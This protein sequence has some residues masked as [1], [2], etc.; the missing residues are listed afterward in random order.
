VFAA[1]YL[2]GVL[3]KFLF[4]S[5]TLILI[6]G[7][8]STPS[9]NYDGFNSAHD[10]CYSFIYGKNDV[11]KSYDKAFKWC[12]IGS[13]KEKNNS[14]T[15]LLAELYL[16]G[17]G[18]EKNILKATELYIK[19]ANTGHTHAQLMIYYIYHIESPELASDKQKKIALKYLK[20]SAKSGNKKAIKMLSKYN[21][22]FKQDK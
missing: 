2:Q 9:N 19:S 6:S 18:V 15:T 13:N 12:E 22:S 14:S 21:K 11:I 7:C 1:L 17:N 20:S 4:F 8:S 5:L 10:A 16:L 3:V